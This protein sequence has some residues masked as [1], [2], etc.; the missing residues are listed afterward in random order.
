MLQGWLVA[1]ALCGAAGCGRTELSTAD[2]CSAERETRACAGFCG[3]GTQTCVAGFWQACEVP[4]VER[5]CD[6]DCGSGTQVCSD[7]GWGA[8][9]V[10]PV[11]ETCVDTCGAGERTCRDDRWSECRVEPVVAPCQ[12][13]CGEGEQVCRDDAWGECEVA[14]T[15]RP[16]ATACGEGL[17]RCEAGRWRACD[18]PQPRPPLLHTTVR[19]LRDTHPDFENDEFAGG[20]LRGLVEKYLGPDDKPVRVDGARTIT[21]DVS[22]VSWYNLV[23]GVNLEQEVPLQLVENQ[24]GDALFEY[25]NHAFF[26]I[27]D[28]LFGNEGRRH[29]Y[30]FTLE[31]ATEF[32]YVGGEIFRFIGDD[33]LWVFINRRLA[34][35]LGSLH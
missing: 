12:N 34:I 21:S 17:E 1:S 3:A 7:G 30:H 5:P 11:T 27:D 20:V 15:S 8:C 6:N 26:P 32:R 24:T 14:P 2:P 25:R 4:V 29:N 13:D 9:Q 28:Q 22:F 19:D 18:A 23:P 31:A 10:A 16:C 33:D 35:D